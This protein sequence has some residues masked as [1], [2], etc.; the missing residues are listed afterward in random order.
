[1]DRMMRKHVERALRVADFARQHPS[2]LPGH[3]A[4]LARL[5]AELGRVAEVAQEET[6]TRRAEEAAIAERK[7]LG[8]Q[9]AAELQLLA[10]IARTAGKESVGTPIVL[11]YPGPKKNQLQ[12]LDGARTV[13]ATAAEQED[14]LVKFGLPADHLASLTAGLERFAG[15]MRARD[16]ASRAHVGARVQIRS[17]ARNLKLV[18]EQMHSINRFRFRKDPAQLAMWRSSRDLRVGT[19]KAAG[20]EVPPNGPLALPPAPDDVRPAA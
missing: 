14:L 15:L 7:E 19:R 8:D 4:A 9:L 2:D 10:G 20:T 13:V 12:F 3:A 17:L 1:M 5:E 16:E 18:V 11:R 6:G